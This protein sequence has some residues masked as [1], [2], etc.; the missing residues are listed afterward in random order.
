MD[1]RETIVL[2]LYEAF[3]RKDVPAMV[4]TLH[5]DASWHN[6]LGPDRL[7][8][9]EVIGRM[10]AEQITRFEVQVSPIALTLEA[11]GSLLAEAYFVIRGINGR[12][13]TEEKGTQRYRFRDGLIVWMELL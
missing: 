7:E 13:F 12:L 11:D 9:A 8:G 4:A 3:D 2:A 5:P 10:W 1:P 6:M